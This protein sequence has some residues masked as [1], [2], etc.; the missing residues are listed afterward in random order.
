MSGG[1]WSYLSIE[2]EEQA[3]QLRRGALGSKLAT[4]RE[5]FLSG[6]AAL[7]VLAVLEHELD[8]GICCDTCYACAVRRVTPALRALFDRWRR[9]DED[10]LMPYAVDAFRHVAQDHS[11]PSLLCP[12]CLRREVDLLARGGNP[13]RN[14]PGYAQLVLIEAARRA[15]ELYPERNP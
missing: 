13:Y 5:T 4:G 7:I 14:S 2:L 15:D 1:H 10:E 9:G 12:G 11:T 6:E 8:W 3:A